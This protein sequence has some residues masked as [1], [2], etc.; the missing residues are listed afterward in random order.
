MAYSF[1]VLT[2]LRGSPV[3]T[4]QVKSCCG[5]HSAGWLCRTMHVPLRKW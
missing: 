2:R 4:M 5:H 1:L 3:S